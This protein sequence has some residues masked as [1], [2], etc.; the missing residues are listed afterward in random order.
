VVGD[1][2]DAFPAADVPE[3]E[4][5]VPGTGREQVGDLVVPGQAS[6]VG[7]VAF[8]QGR[9]MLLLY[10]PYTDCTEIT[11]TLKPCST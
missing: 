4:R 8:K 7:S 11:Q 3:P 6:D 10:L 2:F 9:A 1:R 5:A